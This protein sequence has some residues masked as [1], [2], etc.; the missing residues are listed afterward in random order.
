MDTRIVI[1]LGVLD[2]FKYGGLGRLT[3]E[4]EYDGQSLIILTPQ[5]TSIHAK[6]LSNPI[7]NLEHQR[8][9]ILS[10]L[11]FAFSGF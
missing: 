10:A 2:H 7:G 8:E 5:I 3:P 4:V 6:P 1:P 9:T 11:D